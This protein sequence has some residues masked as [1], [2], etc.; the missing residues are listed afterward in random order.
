MQ[1]IEVCAA[2]TT[3][4]ILLET[5]QITSG[6]GRGLYDCLPACFQGN[7]KPGG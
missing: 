7:Q 5:V 4:W 6:P 3:I 2:E 1:S